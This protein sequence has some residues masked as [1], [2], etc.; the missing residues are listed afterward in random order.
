MKKKNGYLAETISLCFML[1][2]KQ[3]AIRKK[4]EILLSQCHYLKRFNQSTLSVPSRKTSN[5]QLDRETRCG[6]NMQSADTTH[7][8]HRPNVKQRKMCV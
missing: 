2:I 5:S 8:Q 6:A 3:R 4:N 1:M 7:T